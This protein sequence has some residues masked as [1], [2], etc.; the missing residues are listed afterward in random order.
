MDA[1]RQKKT[2]AIIKL[3]LIKKYSLINAMNFLSK[4]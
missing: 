1:V 4:K 3:K 2:N